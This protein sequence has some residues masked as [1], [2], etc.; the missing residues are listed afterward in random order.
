MTDALQTP[1]TF[2]GKDILLCRECM[3]KLGIEYGCRTGGTLFEESCMICDKED[4][5]NEI[6]FTNINLYKAIRKN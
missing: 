4:F 3:R 2:V 6:Q 1:Q 5:L